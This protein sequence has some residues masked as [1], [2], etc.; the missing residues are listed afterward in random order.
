MFLI[1]LWRTCFVLCV[2]SFS[3]WTVTCLIFRAGHIQWHNTDPFGMCVICT[4]IVYFC[5]VDFQRIHELCTTWSFCGTCPIAL[6][7]CQK[8]S[9]LLFVWTWISSTLSGGKFLQPIHQWLSRR[10]IP[11]LGSFWG[12]RLG[13]YR[14][15]TVS[16]YQGIKL[17]LLLCLNPWHRLL[18]RCIVTG[19]C[20]EGQSVN[21][22]VMLTEL[23]VWV[24]E[25]P[26]LQD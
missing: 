9:E 2:C 5:H 11:M 14:F 15:H 10:T 16:D 25:Y 26:R 24:R 18:Q 1:W 17:H 20:A 8:S 19:P 4:I 23:A 21:Q 13:Q 3:L 7:A 12:R 22:G 6:F